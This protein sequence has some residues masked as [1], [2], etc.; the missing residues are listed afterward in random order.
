MLLLAGF[1]V[2]ELVLG[3]VTLFAPLL[4]PLLVAGL[5]VLLLLAGRL[6]LLLLAGRLVVFP[7]VTALIVSEDAGSA[8]VVLPTAHTGPLNALKQ[9]MIIITTANLR[10]FFFIGFLLLHFD[11]CNGDNFV[12]IHR[13]KLFIALF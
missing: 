2:S 13:D 3:L 7:S 5:L 4:V 9:N 10:P 6:V 1:E 8:V 11:V 12:F